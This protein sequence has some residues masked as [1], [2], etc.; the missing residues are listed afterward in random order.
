[1]RK[2]SPIWGSTAFR[3]RIKTV[4]NLTNHVC[5][6]SFHNIYI[7]NESD[8]LAN[9]LFCYLP[10]NICQKLLTSNLRTL[11]NGLSKIQPNDVSDSYLI[12]ITNISHMTKIEFLLFMRIA[13]KNNHL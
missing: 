12:N 5:L 8:T 7:K 4:R 2:P 6:T 11:G 3:N 10:T 13:R 9:V 1:M